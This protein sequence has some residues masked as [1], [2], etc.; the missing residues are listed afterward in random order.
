[1]NY[2]TL[3]PLL[4]AW[5]GSHVS[6]RLCVKYVCSDTVWCDEFWHAFSS[7]PELPASL[8]RSDASKICPFNKGECARE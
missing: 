3:L 6:S 2:E 8:P 7:Q 5:S 4:L 1:M